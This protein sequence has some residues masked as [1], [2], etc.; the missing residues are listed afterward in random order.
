M[1]TNEGSPTA[2]GVLIVEDEVLIRLDLS[3][4]LRAAGLAVFEAATADEGITILESMNSV[5]RS[6][7]GAC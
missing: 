4:Q 1:S 2:R 6:N 5:G 7:A 3:T